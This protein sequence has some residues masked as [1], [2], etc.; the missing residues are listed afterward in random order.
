ME[1]SAGLGAARTRRERLQHEGGKGIPDAA[2]GWSKGL[3]A[4]ACQVSLRNSEEVSGA[5][6]E[7][8]GGP[9][10]H[11][12]SSWRGLSRGPKGLSLLS[13]MGSH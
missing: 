11:E 9:A 2:K 1:Y 12:V 13:E 6:G 10:G 4:G 3:M 7:K 8:L 5:A